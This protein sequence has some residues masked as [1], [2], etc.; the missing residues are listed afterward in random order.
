MKRFC[1]LLLIVLLAVSCGQEGMVKVNIDKAMRQRVS[2]RDLYKE[3]EVIPLRCPAGTALGQQGRVVMDVTAD[4]FFLLDRT[5][6]EVL[7]FDREGAYLTSIQSAAEIIDISVYQDRILDVLTAESVAEY[8]TG[9]CSQLAKYTFQNEDVTLYSVV[10]V[11]DDVIDIYGSKEGIAYDCSYLVSQSR[12]FSLKR[13]NPY[14]L[15]YV[16]AEEYRNSRFFRSGDATWGFLSRSGEI[17][18]FCKDGF[19]APSYFWDFGKWTP[20]FTNVQRKDDRIYFAYEADGQEGV[21]VYDL[22]RKSGK[23]ISQTVEGLAFPLGVIYAGS[24]YFCCSA[25]DLSRYL[26]PDRLKGDDGL[27]MLRFAL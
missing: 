3:V 13:Y 12:F 19:I 16:P 21:L 26:P 25:K 9:D 22:A 24:N 15:A 20:T 17:D 1:Y 11:D 6:N 8:A 23:A 4:R 2:T 10:R 27:V 7:V 5:Q 18:R 14:Q